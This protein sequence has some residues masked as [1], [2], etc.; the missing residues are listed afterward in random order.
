MC[1]RVDP[2]CNARGD[3]WVQGPKWNSI[4]CG[5]HLARAIRTLSG[6]GGERPVV[7][8]VRHQVGDRTV[9]R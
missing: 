1:E 3:F 8:K 7:V 4:V 5:R 6:K 2:P 9:W